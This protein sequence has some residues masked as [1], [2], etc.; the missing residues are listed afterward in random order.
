MPIAKSIA[1]GTKCNYKGRCA[2]ARQQV[3]RGLDIA[4]A[5]L[6]LL[7]ARRELA[8]QVMAWR[9]AQVKLKEA[10][11]LLAFECCQ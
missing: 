9:I 11:G 8:H 7:D 4:A 6:Q 1:S 2:A 5:D 10:Q 3:D